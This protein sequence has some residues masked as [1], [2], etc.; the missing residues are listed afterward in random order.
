M[1][2][3]DLLIAVLLGVFL[4]LWLLPFARDGVDPHHDGIMLKPALDVLSGQ[5]LFRDSFTQYGALTT[6]LQVIALSI[7]PTLLS[8]RFMTIG[9]Y[10]VILCGLYALWRQILPRPLAAFSCGLFV[11]FLPLYEKDWFGAQWILLPWSSAYALMF[12]VIALGALCQVI[13]DVQAARWSVV[14]GVACACVFWCRQPVGVV[15][16]GCV[17]AIWLALYFAGWSPVHTSRRAIAT[18]MIAGFLLVNALAVASLIVTDALPAWWYQNFTW[19]AKWAQHMENELRAGYFLYPVPAAGLLLLLLAI[20]APS[21]AARVGFQPGRRLVTA[22]YVGLGALALWQH[23]HVLAWLTWRFG[24]WT[25]VIPVVALAAGIA[26]LVLVFWKRSA[27]R[28]TEYYLVAAI[29]AMAGG[30]L[31][32]YYPLPD[33][34]HVVWAMAPALGLVVYVFWRASRWPAPV[35]TLVLVAAF[36]PSIWSKA[37]MVREALARPLI[38]L[39]RPAVLRG[40]RAPAEAAQRI[41]RIAAL[42]EQVERQRPDISTVVIGNDALFACFTHNLT[43]PTAFY[44]TWAGLGE[45]AD[46]QQRWNYIHANRPLMFLHH[47]RWDAVAEFYR[48]ERYV[49][50]LYFHEDALEVAVPQEIADALGVTTYGAPKPG[51]AAPPGK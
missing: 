50:L 8:L 5:A 23:Y 19:P 46:S 38:T 33:P 13:R 28:T 11:L 45:P 48:K 3:T 6:Y 43:N 18:R 17:A 14:V 1:K 34:W 30:A 47:A 44:V 15:T 40:M 37:Q 36:A 2:R 16:T 21:L 27:P 41:D 4:A 10:V 49:P 25:I 20:L 26:C 9:A 31:L 29:A 39:E 24:G 32:Q 42:V 35:A 22:Y 12:Q 7:E 51:A